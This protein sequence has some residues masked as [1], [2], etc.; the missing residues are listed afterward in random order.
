[1]AMLTSKN[2]G[3]LIKS[4]VIAIILIVLGWYLIMNNQLLYNS[5]GVRFES[6]INY[7]SG[8]KSDSSTETRADY[9]SQAI[10]MFK[11]NPII[12][13]GLDGFRFFNNRRCWAE[14]NYAEIL[15]DLGF[16]GAIIYYIFPINLLWNAIKRRLNGDIEISVIVTFMICFLFVIDISMVT[17]SNDSLQLYLVFS[18][19]VFSVENSDSTVKLIKKER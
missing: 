14:N 16:I 11:E 5:V 8:M 9:F 19:I 6:L 4:S 2:I 13:I 10:G 15:A 17:Y 3:N 18:Y 7:F 1:M 12:G